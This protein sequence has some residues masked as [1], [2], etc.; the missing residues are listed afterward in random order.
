V[1]PV[2]CPNTLFNDPFTRRLF[3]P[4][5]PTPPP[6]HSPLANMTVEKLTAATARQRSGHGTVMSPKAER[7]W[8]VDVV[9]KGFDSVACIEIMNPYCHIPPV[10]APV[11]A[12]AGN[13]NRTPKIVR[14]LTDAYV[15]QTRASL[16]RPHEMHPYIHNCLHTHTHAQTHTHRHTGTQAHT[17]KLHTAHVPTHTL[18]TYACVRLTNTHTRIHTFAY[19]THTCKH[20]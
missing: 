1:K 11:P 14:L 17:K 18:L 8:V 7:R 6:P 4:P 15:R 2:N 20:T 19:R 9:C 3:P 13:T 10:P 16:A 5:P 12:R